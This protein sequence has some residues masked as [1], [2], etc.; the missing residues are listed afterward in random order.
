MDK[1]TVIATCLEDARLATS[2]FDGMNMVKREFRRS[3]GNKVFEEWNTELGD[4]KAEYIIKE[5]KNAKTSINV[6]GLIQQLWR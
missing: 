3:F 1:M 6:K 5:A 2:V 4:D